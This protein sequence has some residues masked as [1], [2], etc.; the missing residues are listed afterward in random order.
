M[1]NYGLVKLLL[2]FLKKFIY[3]YM[4]TYKQTFNMIF[5]QPKDKSNTTEEMSKL[6][7]IPVK[8]LNEVKSRGEGAYSSNLSSVRLKGSYKKDDDM[9]KG[10]SKRLSMENW[11][12][13]RQYAFIVKSMIG[14]EQSKKKQDED[15]Y[16]KI[17]DKVKG[18][19]L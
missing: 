19:S 1:K 6:S 13:A 12:I 3:I 2:N 14:M 15:L 4:P 10:V 7:N 5:N 8:I 16:M 17:K 18:I 9:R 11:S